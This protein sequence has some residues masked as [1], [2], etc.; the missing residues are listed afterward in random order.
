M[1]NLINDVFITKK[2]LPFSLLFEE[3]KSIWKQ[4]ED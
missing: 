3:K 4:L 2:T 1:K